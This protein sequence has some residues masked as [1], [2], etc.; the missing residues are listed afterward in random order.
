MDD[1]YRDIPGYVGLYKININGEV[2]YYPRF[3][4]IPGHGRRF[5]K[6][7]VLKLEKYTSGCL[8]ARL[9]KN[10]NKK[11]ISVSKLVALAFD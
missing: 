10:G 11:S 7:G 9:R 5:Y 6:S 8:F 2:I 4:I 1:E 3:V